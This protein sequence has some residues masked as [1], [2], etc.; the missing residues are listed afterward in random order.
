MPYSE[1]IYASACMILVRVYIEFNNRHRF[2]VTSVFHVRTV[3]ART[4]LVDLRAKDRGR[5]SPG[6]VY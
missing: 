5:P 2:D 6:V 1:G 3:V 4:S